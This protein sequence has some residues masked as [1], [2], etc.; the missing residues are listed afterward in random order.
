MPSAA[1]IEQRQAFLE[2]LNGDDGEL[3]T[4]TR[5]AGGASKVRALINRLGPPPAF[6]VAGGDE[7]IG[8]V[9]Q[10]AA[11]V[12]QP[13]IGDFFT[14]DQNTRHS[15]IERKSL[16]HCWECKCSTRG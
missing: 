11:S 5:A 16:G 7:K 9:I 13:E 2:L 15:I 3:V 12:A 6:G 4:L 10:I 1:A 8:A 14:D